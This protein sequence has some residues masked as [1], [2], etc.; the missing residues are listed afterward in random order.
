MAT[1]GD[2]SSDPR[3]QRSFFRRDAATVARELLGQQ[4]VYI[5]K[6]KRLAGLIVET[7]AYLGVNDL[8]AHTCN[9]KHTPRNQSMWGDG[10]L[11]Y[12]YFTYGMH[13]CLNVVASEQGDP[14]AV[15]I[16][17]LEPTQGLDIMQSRRKAARKTRDLCSGPAK[18]CQALGIDRA[19]D[20]IDLVSDSHLFIEQ[21]HTGCLE[22]EQIIERPR[23]GV[24]YAKQWREALL[25]FY[26]KDNCYISRP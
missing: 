12:V 4:L 8:A 1:L 3:L 6:G 19:S 15:L 23:I 20:G 26:I 11:L 21:T 2:N 16:R 24:D 18:L 17:A 22:K 14:V 10:G 7:E 5:D 25:R 13:H 9:G